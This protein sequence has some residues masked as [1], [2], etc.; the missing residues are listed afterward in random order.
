MLFWPWYCEVEENVSPV[1]TKPNPRGVY[2]NRRLLN[3]IPPLTQQQRLAA[4]DNAGWVIITG[5]SGTGLTHTLCCRGLS[6][7]NDGVQPERLL[8]LT[9]S[10]GGVEAIHETFEEWVDEGECLRRDAD[11]DDLRQ[12]AEQLLRN[13]R[14]ALESPVQTM[15][16]FCLQYMRDEGARIM[17]L[18]Q[19]L[20]FL[21]H[22]QQLQFVSRLAA[23]DAATRGL[24]TA[25]LLEFLLW[26]RRNAA[27][28]NHLDVGY[29]RDDVLRDWIYGEM[30]VAGHVQWATPMPPPDETWLDLSRRYTEEKRRQGI[31]DA[32]E[33]V[34][35]AARARYQVVDHEMKPR[36]YGQHVMMDEVQEMT[37]AALEFIL[38]EKLFVETVAI[39]YNPN[40]RTGMWRGAD[41]GSFMSLVQ[42]YDEPSLHNL[43][44]DT[45][46]TATLADFLTR[47]TT[48]PAL[49]GLEARN[50]LA[51]RAAGESPQLRVFR[52]RN[53]L[54]QALVESIQG[55]Y[56]TDENLQQTACL[57]RQ[58]STM[59]QC[60]ALLEAT[61]IP[62]SVLGTARQDQDHGTR[63]LV[64][65]LTLLL[66]SQD[67]EAFSDAGAMWTPGGWRA[68]NHCTEGALAAESR[69]RGI[70]LVKAAAGH[71]RTLTHGSQIR[72]AI[73][74]ILHGLEV[75]Q[76]MLDN[77]VEDP[78]LL[79]LCG[80]AF[81]SLQDD[82]QPRP[83]RGDPVFRL[84]EHTQ[85]F[86]R[87]QGETLPEC[88]RRFLD[89]ITIDGVPHQD[90]PGIT[91]STIQDA[92]GLQW[93]TGWV[94]EAG[95]RILPVQADAQQPP[96][97]L[98]EEQRLVSAA[99]SR[100]RDTV[101]FFNLEGSDLERFW[102]QL[103]G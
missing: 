88:L 4:E 8:Y 58:A 6:F 37:P 7:I 50:A 63:R 79:H 84:L 57:F 65:L 76:G 78:V 77:G 24:S 25:E 99:A 69:E 34:R 39:A 38:T 42:D 30:V 20:S 100:A 31:I 86:P 11:R 85:G 96:V 15:E 82:N 23:Q 91:L 56:E 60:R 51:Y 22:R 55:R 74:K 87:R 29:G 41:P 62:C 48:I 5:D 46:S 13:A 66:N 94:V 68:L 83:V 89:S 44:I 64:G 75:V 14:R 52:D 27:C 103:V 32:D 80:R 19:N 71:I 93:N 47:L 97:P 36:R 81:L 53:A 33:V 95:E 67:L 59:E 45:R 12:T 1:K 21:T 43:R 28:S 9:W 92:R 17:G 61:G 26:R 2:M 102:S 16:Q 98:W 54:V 10:L 18:P 101:V 73:R 40:Q 35:T 70:D 3:Q 72:R 49:A 90:Q